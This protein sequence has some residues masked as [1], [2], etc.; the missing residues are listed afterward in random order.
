MNRRQILASL[1]TMTGAGALA[2]GDARVLHE[3]PLET[4][5][6][7][8]QLPDVHTGS[9]WRVFDAPAREA[10]AA[11]FDRL[12]PGDNHGP[13][14]TEAGCLVFLDA[15]LDGPYGEGRDMYLEGPLAADESSL[16]GRDVTLRQRREHYRA[17]LAALESHAVRAFGV[18]IAKLPAARLDALLAQMEAGKIALGDGVNAKAFF[19]LMLQN[20]REGYF[21]DPLYGG[22]RNMA[23]WKMLG[24][25]GARYDYRPYMD[26]RGQDLRLEPISLLPA[27]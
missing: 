17:G 18:G 5:L 10:L 2:R 6:N 14:A 9:E 15:Q 22:N 12:V 25:P 7:E 20:V 13:S 4:G 21:A 23:G 26:R 8:Q 1:G 24:F 11:V 19:E 16:M 3:V 27:D